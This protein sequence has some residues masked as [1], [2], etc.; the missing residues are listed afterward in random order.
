MSLKQLLWGQQLVLSSDLL[1][2]V[3]FLI[4]EVGIG[5]PFLYAFSS[6]GSEGVERALQILHVSGLSDIFFH[7]CVIDIHRTSLR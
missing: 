3:L 2:P 4:C 1:I 7:S 5:R 6:Y